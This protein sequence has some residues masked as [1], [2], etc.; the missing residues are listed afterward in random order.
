[1]PFI[2]K[3][4]LTPLTFSF[5]FFFWGYFCHT[6]SR[7]ESSRDFPIRHHHPHLIPEVFLKKE[8]PTKANPNARAF[9][10]MIPH[11]QL[12]YYGMVGNPDT[13]DIQNWRN[14]IKECEALKVNTWLEIGRSKLYFQ[15]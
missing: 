1:M 2:F 7:S 4:N 6:T 13:S 15:R 14:F 12:E 3:E 5:L 8:S 9:L 10:I 11:F